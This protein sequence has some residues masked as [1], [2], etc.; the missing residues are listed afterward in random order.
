MPK[1]LDLD[2]SVHK[3]KAGGSEFTVTLDYSEVLSQKENKA[4][5]V[6]QVLRR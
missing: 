4:T 3:A 1:A 6:I 5:P 2:P